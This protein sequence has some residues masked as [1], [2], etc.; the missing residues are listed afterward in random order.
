MPYNF[1]F[2]SSHTLLNVFF[3]LDRSRVCLSTTQLFSRSLK[4]CPNSPPFTGSSESPCCARFLN[5]WCSAPDP[6]HP[7][8]SLWR[9]IVLSRSYE[10]PLSRAR[11]NVNHVFLGKPRE[12]PAARQN[13]HPRRGLALGDG[14]LG[15]SCSLNV[16]DVASC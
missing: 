16:F 3:V 1:F 14:K 12:R 10:I 5:P 6:Y 8:L 11:W 7:D 9:G 15:L 13:R 2:F 4:Q